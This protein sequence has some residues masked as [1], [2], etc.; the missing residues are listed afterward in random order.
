[1]ADDGDHYRLT[2]DKPG[3]WSQKYNL[4]WDKLL[5]LN[6]FPK[7][8]APKELAY[9]L[10]KQNRYGLPLDN[11]E[12]YTKADWIVWTATMADDRATFERFI[13]PMYDFMNQTVDRVPMSDWFF[14]D[15]PNRRGFMARAVVGGY[16]I[17][18]LEPKIKK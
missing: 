15:K 3:T 6:V 13:D 17:K 5:K 16:W 14:T 8:V 12:T 18:M 9:Y 4:V 11:R 1:M 10:T 2:F 7:E